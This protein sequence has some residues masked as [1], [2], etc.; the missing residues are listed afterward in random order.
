MSNTYEHFAE[1]IE[2]LIA[3]L[4]WAPDVMGEQ[5]A[6]DCR[7]ILKYFEDKPG[8][9]VGFG[10]LAALLDD[11]EY[12]RTMEAT[13]PFMGIGMT[14]PLFKAR[15]SGGGYHEITAEDRERGQLIVPDTGEV[16]SIADDNITI[17]WRIDDFTRAP[18]L[19][20]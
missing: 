12:G 7:A 9:D 8:Q 1:R 11:K 3:N 20:V 16:V 15:D 5:R 4:A 10:E 18:S 13:G 2:K 14:S 19:K 6:S 17:F